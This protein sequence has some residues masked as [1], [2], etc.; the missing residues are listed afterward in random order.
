[1]LAGM[2]GQGGFAAD[3]RDRQLLGGDANERIGWRLPVLQCSASASGG[4]G[5]ECCHDHLIGD[6]LRHLEAFK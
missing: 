4:Q 6:F 1:M 5:L 3:G 2:N